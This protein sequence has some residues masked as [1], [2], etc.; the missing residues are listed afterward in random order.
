LSSKANLLKRFEQLQD[1]LG[2]DNMPQ[3]LECFDISHTFGEA[4]VASCVVMDINGPLKS[5]YRKFN[6][7]GVTPGD[8]YGAMRQALTRRYTRLKRGESKIPDVLFIDGGKGQLSEALKVMEELQVSGIN[9]VGIAKGPERKAGLEVLFTAQ[10]HH[11][12]TLPPESP[13]L[14]LIQQVRDEAHR[15]AISAHKQRRSKARRSSVLEEIPGLGPKRRQLILKRLGGLQEVSRAG[16]E[17]LAQLPGI[18]RHLAQRIY[19][20]LHPDD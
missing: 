12:I 3:R 18:S 8:D 15:F 4:P 13:A 9:V 11:G 20:T 1:A 16:V 6:I 5:D 17:D 2:L 14:H 7:E 10:N 19:D